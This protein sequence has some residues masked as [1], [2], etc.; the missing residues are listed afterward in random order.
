MFIQIIQGIIAP[1]FDRMGL[2]I[3]LFLGHFEEQKDDR[4]KA[5]N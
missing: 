2:Y 4:E 3:W 5:K 1:S